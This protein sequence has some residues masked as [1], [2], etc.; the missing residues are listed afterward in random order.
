[1][2]MCPVKIDELITDIFSIFLLIPMKNFLEEFYE[3]VSYRS[4]EQKI[5]ISTEEWIKYLAERAGVSEYYVAYGY[6]YLRS[7]AYWIYQAWTADIDTL[8][9]IKM[10]KDEMKEIK[11][12]ISQE[13]FY[14]LKDW[15][16]QNE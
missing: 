9:E 11:S 16:Y 14:S 4:K 13:E 6:Q 5:P 8:K 15:I 1:M 3:Y 12:W 2:P 7:S 10:S